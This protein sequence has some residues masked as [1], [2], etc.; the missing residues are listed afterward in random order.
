MIPMRPYLVRALYDWIV[1]N[2]LT[3]YLL[4]NAEH[5]QIEVP[6]QYVEN[7]KIILNISPQ[8]VQGLT[9][10]DDWVSFSTR[11]SGRAF[12]VFVPTSAV[13]AIYARENGKGMFFQEEP[14]DGSEPE[15]SPP[16]QKPPRR[17]KPTL[18]L[19]K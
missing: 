3:P 6:R 17:G 7:G 13:L 10:D 18:K 9:L 14:E 2:G 8:A 1:D 5:E 15:L 11:F 19:V 12:S 4:A 16:P